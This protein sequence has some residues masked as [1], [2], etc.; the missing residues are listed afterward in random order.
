MVPNLPRRKFLHLLGC[1]AAASTAPSLARAEVYPARHVR[2]IVGFPAGGVADV[3]A[4]L[5]GQ[6]LS[7]RL[8][9]PFIIENRAGAGGNIATEAVVHAPPDGHTLLMVSIPHAINASL[10]EKLNFN[11]IRDVTLVGATRGPLVVAVHP[12]VPVKTIP[13]LLAY[14]RANPG[15][16]A[17]ASAGSGSVNH[18]AGELF[19][20]MA[21]IDMT[22]VPYR[23]AGPAVADL[24]GC[25]TVPR[26]TRDALDLRL[27]K[28]RVTS[29]LH[30]RVCPQ[31]TLLYEPHA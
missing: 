15:K 3:L 13:E 1:T 9:M 14:A 12:S 11:F 23:G 20:A 26:R 22:H 24:L 10:Y 31:A 16:I 18:M 21:S 7:E 4:R 5:I 25:L 19:K 28:D 6:W 29:V 27:Q 17:M 30:R 8:H 2:L